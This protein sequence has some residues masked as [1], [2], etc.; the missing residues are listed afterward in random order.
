MNARF[1]WNHRFGDVWRY[2]NGSINFA[3]P[4]AGIDQLLHG[5]DHLRGWGLPASPDPILYYVR[6]FNPTA[7][8]FIYDVNPRFGNTRPSV[9][10]L[11]SPFR[12]TVDISF[13]L[14]GNVSKQQLEIYLRPTRSSPGVR[15]PA[16]T[17]LRRLRSTGISA[18][19]PYFWIMANADSL[20]LSR[21]QVAELN[22]G[23]ERRRVAIDSTYEALAR[24]LA[25]LPVVYDADAAM[26]RVQETNRS[27]FNWPA[28]EAVF[29]RRVLTPIQI[30]LLPAGFERNYLTGSERP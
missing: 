7:K 2:V 12:I 25:A 29:L 18:A 11:Y 19:S 4:L 5:G 15:P 8:Q 13:S 6:G 17:I 3:N 27:I 22:A 10:A 26:K 21:E 28:S 24:E 1:N 23:A 14:N 9:S 16:D 30:R 20:L